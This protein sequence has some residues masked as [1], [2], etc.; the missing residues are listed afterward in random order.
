MGSGL[1]DPQNPHASHRDYDDKLSPW[2][3]STLSFSRMKRFLDELM[4]EVGAP[5]TF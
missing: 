1:Y 3:I 2:I 4:Q 5:Q